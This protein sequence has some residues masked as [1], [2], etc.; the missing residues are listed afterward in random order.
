[1][2]LSAISL[3]PTISG[4]QPKTAQFIY[5]KTQEGGAS[6][7]L[8]VRNLDSVERDES[9]NAPL[10]VK[11]ATSQETRRFMEWVQKHRKEA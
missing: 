2:N 6:Q 7:I 4:D 11:C 5:L 10:T 1:Q 3:P 8:I 9:R